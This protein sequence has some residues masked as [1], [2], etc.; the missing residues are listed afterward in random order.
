MPRVPYLA[1]AS[2]PSAPCPEC[3]PGLFV[4]L[5]LALAACRSTNE[6]EHTAPSS[7]PERFS[8][9]L[10]SDYAKLELRGEGSETLRA[11][12]GAR[13]AR[14]DKGFTID[15]GES[16]AL[17]IASNAPP[18]SE[19]APSSV[20]RVFSEPDLAVFKSGQGA[21]SFVVVRELVPEWDDNARQRLSCGSSGGVVGAEASGAAVRGFSKSAVEQMVAACRSLALP[22]L[23]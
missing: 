4:A 15:A 12:P 16:F 7:E 20:A 10:P 1:H 21:Y 19:L 8:F 14:G 23:E 13:V 5:A 3:V 18:L 9:A 6:P 22:A 11:P 2:R 17:T